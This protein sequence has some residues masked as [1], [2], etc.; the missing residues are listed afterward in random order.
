MES[1]MQNDDANAQVV[2]MPSLGT[3]TTEG[4]VARWLRLPGDRVLAGEVIA[5]IVTDKV[6]EELLTPLAGTL[7]PHIVA[8]GQVAPVGTALVVISP[9]WPRTEGPSA[10]HA[11]IDGL[12]PEMAADAKPQLDTDARARSS[13]LVRRLADE[14]HID[15]STVLGSGPGGRVTK[16]D[17]AAVVQKRGQSTRP[18]DSD[19]VAADVSSTPEPT[20]ALI[21]RVTSLNG[22]AVD[23]LA[24][25]SLRQ[26]VAANLVRAVQGVPQAWT[27]VEVDA[28]ALLAFR[29]TNR[30]TI[31]AMTGLILGS[32]TVFVSVATQA[33]A[34]HP[35]LNGA[36][37][38]G[39]DGV[40]A[41]GD[42]GGRIVTYRDVNAGIAVARPSGGVFV[43]VVRDAARLDLATLAVALDAAINGARENTLKADGYAGAT[44]TL[45]NTGALGSVVSHPILPTCTS[46]IITLEAIVRRPVVVAGDAITIRP[47]VNVCLTFDHR[48]LD[49][50]EACAFL[51]DLKRRLETLD[52]GALVSIA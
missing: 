8:A 42:A 14:H 51:Q 18:V 33:I 46:A 28:T 21:S 26:T 6:S 52:S 2:R 44:V 30:A 1:S 13:P 3:M 19:P 20:A 43:P 7:G 12:Q 24:P 36:W 41:I 49:G 16:D 5:E 23:V 47:M 34:D 9:D 15:L 25:S 31:Q 38:D 32:F 35:L 39:P 17:I 40:G 4:T 22:Q 11:H 37:R 27:L 45:N 50:L 10:S 29:D 48:V